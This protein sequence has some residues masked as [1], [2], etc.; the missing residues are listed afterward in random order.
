MHINVKDTSGKEVAPGVVEK[1][2]LKREGSLGEINVKHYTL[3]KGGVIEYGSPLTEYQHYVVQGCAAMNAPDGGLLHQDSAWF[4]P[5]NSP[6]GD[7]AL[8]GHSLYHVGEGEVKILSVSYKGD[9]PAFRWAKSRSRNIHQVPQ[10][11]SAGRLLNYVQIFKE[12]DHA[13]MGALRMHGIDVQTNP[14]GVGLPEHRNPEEIL[15]VLRGKGVAVSEGES[16]SICSGSLVYTPEG[17]VHGIRDVEK[18][19]EYLVIEFID[20]A[21]MWTERSQP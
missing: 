14:P 21:A 15:Y 12:E 8:R 9:R 1:N 6:W 13:V 7:E 5:C 16:H 20:H 3:S 18:T 10:L 4:V 17:A 19:L 2:L 11:H